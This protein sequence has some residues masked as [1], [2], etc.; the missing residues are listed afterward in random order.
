MSKIITIKT[1][2]REIAI[3]LKEDLTNILSDHVNC[4]WD[5][6]RWQVE[7]N[8]E[9]AEVN[10]IRLMIDQCENYTEGKFNYTIED[11]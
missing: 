3:R 9:E 8:A 1:D 4:I 10:E 11:E 5:D 7:A 2:D 6:G